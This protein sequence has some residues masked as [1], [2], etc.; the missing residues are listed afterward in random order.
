MKFKLTILVFLI[1]ILTGCSLIFKPGIDKAVDLIFHGI[2]PDTCDLFLI[3]NV[4]NYRRDSMK[5]PNYASVVQMK[6][7]QSIKCQESFDSLNVFAYGLDSVDIFMIKIFENTENE[8]YSMLKYY[9]LRFKNDS[10]ENITPHIITTKDKYH[11]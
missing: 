7:T 9:R 1:I 6:Q 10:L 2:I 3:N 5:F 4:A 8:Q 11:Y